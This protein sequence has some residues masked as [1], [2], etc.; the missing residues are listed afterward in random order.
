M[1]PLSLTASVLHIQFV[2]ILEA[3]YL[4]SYILRLLVKM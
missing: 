1:L 3:F 2:L 4:L